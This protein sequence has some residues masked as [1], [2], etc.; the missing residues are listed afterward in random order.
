MEALAIAVVVAVAAVVMRLEVWGS[1]PQ[2]QVTAERAV[3]WMLLASDSAPYTGE[4][5]ELAEAAL[6]SHLAYIE[7][8]SSRYGEAVGEAYAVRALWLG[9]NGTLQPVEVVVGARP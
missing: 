6:G 9:Y 8:G 4:L 7:W 5:V 1:E 3:A 2:H